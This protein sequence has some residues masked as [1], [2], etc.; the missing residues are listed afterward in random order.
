MDTVILF[1][2]ALGFCAFVM[3][4]YSQQAAKDRVALSRALAE[5]QRVTSKTLQDAMERVT[6]AVGQSVQTALAPPPSVPLTRHELARE[7]FEQ[8]A[9]PTYNDPTDDSDPTDWAIAPGPRED[10]VFGSASDVAQF[11]GVPPDVFA[12]PTGEM[13]V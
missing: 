2:L 6:L 7:L 11:G 8:G 9:V 4:H 1:L 12:P 3:W 13:G 5:S 10:V